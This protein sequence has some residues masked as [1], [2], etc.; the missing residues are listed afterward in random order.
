MI[1]RL[2]KTVAAQTNGSFCTRREML[3]QSGMGLG[4]CGLA[5]IFGQ[6]PAAA[7]E[8]E[9]PLAPSRPNSRPKPNTSF[10]FS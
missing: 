8:F 10:I 4:I 2:L 7:M 1:D 9:N 3:M 5:S 6:S